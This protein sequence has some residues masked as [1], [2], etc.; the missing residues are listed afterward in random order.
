MAFKS[1]MR[2]IVLQRR[3]PPR[4]PARAGTPRRRTRAARSPDCG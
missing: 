4:R 2:A 1:C 3:R